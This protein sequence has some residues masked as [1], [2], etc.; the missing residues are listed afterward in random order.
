MDKSKSGYI[1]PGEGSSKKYSNVFKQKD[2]RGNR[3]LIQ[4]KNGKIGL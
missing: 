3:F 1:E 2:V 4:M